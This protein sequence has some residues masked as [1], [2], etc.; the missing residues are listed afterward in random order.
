MATVTAHRE[1]T[2]TKMVT[3]SRDWAV[4]WAVIEL[5]PSRDW[6]VIILK[7]PWLSCDLPVTE[8]WPSRDLSCDLAITELCSAA[9]KAKSWVA[10][11]TTHDWWLGDPSQFWVVRQLYTETIKNQLK[12][13]SKRA[14]RYS[15][16]IQTQVHR[17]TDGFVQDCSL[18]GALAMEILQ[19]C[20]K[21]WIWYLRSCLS[22]FLPK[23][24][25]QNTKNSLFAKRTIHGRT[26]GR[27]LDSWVAFGD[28]ATVFQQH[29]LWP[30]LAVTELWSLGPGAVTTVSSRW[31]H[32]DHLFSH[33]MSRN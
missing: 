28:R 10:Q 2:V 22:T 8:L 1:L 26:L 9:E 25:F 32:G 11:W 21:P 30:L 33:G 23:Y 20:A 7:M 13:W 18:S 16:F 31:A 19:S 29:W 17:H 24:F 3:A 4:T 15:R 14:N 27:P 12:N 6:V 5:W